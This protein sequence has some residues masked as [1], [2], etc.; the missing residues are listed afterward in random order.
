MDTAVK[1]V[2][3]GRGRRRFPLGINEPGL[4]FHS[5]YTDL[6]H[7]SASSVRWAIRGN[8]R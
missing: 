2:Q 1:P 4:G 7:I 5:C 8:E 3:T 6:W